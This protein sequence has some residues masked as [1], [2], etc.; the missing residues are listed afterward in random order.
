MRIALGLSLWAGLLAGSA[1][2]ATI[3]FSVTNLSGNQYRYTYTFSGFTLAANQAVDLLF[4]P[5]VYNT[6][7][8]GIVGTGFSLLL[9]QPNTPPGSNGVYTAEATVNN[10]SLAGPFSVDFFY[11][12]I[13]TPGS[14]PFTIDQFDSGGTFVS[15]LDSGITGV[16]EPGSFTL[17]AAGLLLVGGYA[18][19]RRSKRTVQTSNC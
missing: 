14:Q 2:A 3:Q 10:P 9:L 7:S 18:I 19:R 6:L 13:G 1:T 11:T 4:D 15:Q 5:T 8:N 12:G 16:P 17:A